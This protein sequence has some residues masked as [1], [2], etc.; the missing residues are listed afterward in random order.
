MCAVLSPHISQGS[1]APCLDCRLL[2]QTGW[3]LGLLGLCWGFTCSQS[4]QPRNW[5]LQSHCQFLQ[6]CRPC[7]LL[8]LLHPPHLPHQVCMQKAPNHQTLIFCCL[9]RVFPQFLQKLYRP[10]R[11]AS[12]WVEERPLVPKPSFMEAE[13]EQNGGLATRHPPPVPYS[14]A[15]S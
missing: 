12:L 2:S 4:Q 5:F 14:G 13:L 8:W 10:L 1:Q 9:A 7:Q 6:P 3:Q 11:R 15:I